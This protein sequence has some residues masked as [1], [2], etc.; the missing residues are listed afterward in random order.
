MSQRAIPKR[1]KLCGVSTVVM[2]Q[3][4]RGGRNDGTARAARNGFQDPQGRAATPGQG[5]GSHR[6]FGGGTPAAP[7][8]SSAG[9]SGRPTRPTYNVTGGPRSPRDLAHAPKANG[10]FWRSPYTS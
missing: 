4:F 3:A 9:P 8:P 10:L 2:G 5:A 6:L 1:Q 7:P